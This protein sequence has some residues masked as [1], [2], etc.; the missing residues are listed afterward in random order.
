MSETES[1]TY[2]GSC[3]CGVVAYFSRGTNRDGR[4]S[5]AINLRC[6]KGFDVTKLPVHAFDGA[7]L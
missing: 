6:L 7:S 5:V 1:K 3:H 4:P 2:H